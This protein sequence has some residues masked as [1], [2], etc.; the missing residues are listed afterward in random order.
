MK[1]PK[2]EQQKI[3]TT[4]D[5]F[6]TYTNYSSNDLR[7]IADRMDD[8]DILSISLEIFNNYGDYDLKVNQTTLESINEM[9]KRYKRELKEWEN[10]KSKQK[11]KL[12]EIDQLIENTTHH[13]EK[14][15]SE[16][17]K[18]I[19]ELLSKSLRN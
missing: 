19:G 6:N 17:K 11:E 14:V 7:D 2:K 10:Q 16:A 12:N 3:I 1:R 5:F 15:S 9:E 18:K 4:N 8:Q 13:D